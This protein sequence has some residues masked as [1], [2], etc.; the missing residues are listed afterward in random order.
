MSADSNNVIP[1]QRAI[2]TFLAD[3]LSVGGEDLQ[4]NLL[5]AG[6]VQLGGEDN[7]IDM[8]NDEILQFRRPVDFS[9]LQADGITPAGIGG[10]ILS[11]MLLVRSDNDTV[12]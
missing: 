8:N 7:K 6:N 11:Q 10:T 2:A 1:T 9:G 5:Q 3:R 4:T 12:Q